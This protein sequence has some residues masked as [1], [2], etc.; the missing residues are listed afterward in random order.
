VF[1]S[2]VVT[3]L[4]TFERM[5]LGK[6]DLNLAVRQD[7]I[8]PGIRH[9]GFGRAQCKPELLRRIDLRCVRQQRRITNVI[10]IPTSTRVVIR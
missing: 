10:P 8:I 4:E 2:D 1:R 6:R 7:Q 9:S 5:G 3:Q